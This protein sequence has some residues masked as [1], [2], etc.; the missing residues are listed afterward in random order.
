MTR[1]F[2][3]AQAYTTNRQPVA[4]QD[5]QTSRGDLAKFRPSHTIALIDTSLPMPC[6]KKVFNFSSH[7]TP[8][9][10][11]TIISFFWLY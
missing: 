4:V 7:G 6:H 9:V 11:S 8:L 3:I 2:L 1:P 10:Y 5:L